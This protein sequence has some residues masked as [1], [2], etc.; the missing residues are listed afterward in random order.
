MTSCP[1]CLGTR[2]RLFSQDAVRNFLECSDCRLIFVDRVELITPESEK[3]RYDAH[4]NDSNDEGYKKYLSQIT[5]AI[6]PELMAGARGLD[7]GCGR[8]TV[9]ASQLTALS[10]PTDSYDVYFLK[11]EKIW[12][13]KYDF[14]ILS[15]VIEHLRAPR[16]AMERLSKLLLPR[17]KIF[18]K[19][20]FLPA[21]KETFDAWFYKRDIT[22][23]QFFSPHSMEYLKDLLKMSEFRQLE[24]DLSLLALH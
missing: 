17:G 23:V 6:I 19:T 10:Y 5:E 12:T 20:K 14:I 8:T 18:I 22:H 21:S 11:D 13:R 15:E 1:L 4:Q 2:A 7:F 3:T 9:L 24:P 16:E